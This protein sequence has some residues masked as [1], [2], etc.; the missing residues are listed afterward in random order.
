MFRRL[1]KKTVYTIALIKII[2]IPTF[3]VLTYKKE[4]TLT[5]MIATVGHNTLKRVE[6]RHQLSVED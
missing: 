6:V 2:V 3:F 4:Q 1:H 5:E